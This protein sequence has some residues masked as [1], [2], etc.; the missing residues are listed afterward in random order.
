LNLVSIR[1]DEVSCDSGSGE[2]PAESRIEKMSNDQR[3]GVLWAFAASM[4]IA[5]FVIPWKIANSLGDTR[6]NTLVLLTAAASFNTALIVIQQRSLPR[7]RNFDL[8]IAFALAVVTLAGNLASA[9]AIVQLSPALL[10]VIQRSEVIIVALLAWPLIGERIDRRF[11]VG[12]VFAGCGLVVLQDP[13]GSGAVRADGM[14]LA[15]F[16]ALCF[17]SMAVLTRK[18]IRRFD[19]VAVNALRLWISV[20]LWFVVN[21]FPDQLLQASS[22]Q[23]GYACLTAFFGPFLGRLCLMT[24]AKYVEARITTLV[25][26]SAPPMTLV[27]AYL[28]LD[29]LPSTREIQGGLIMLAGIAIPVFVWARSD[30]RSADRG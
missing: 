10:T 7:I 30:S 18:Y 2:A 22:P 19:L 11:V 28:V 5:G 12:A 4:G 17:A 29:D 16:S 24:S 25:T 27:L 20:G 13:F 3:R 26:L 21:G 9:R 8:R 15:L 1:F 6:V 23:V 14:T